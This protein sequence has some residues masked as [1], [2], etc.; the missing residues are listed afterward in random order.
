MNEVTA[1]GHAVERA[2]KVAH[3]LC[4]DA[5]PTSMMLQKRIVDSWIRYPFDAAVT[6]SMYVTSSAYNSGW[7]QSA[8]T[9]M[10]ERRGG[11]SELKR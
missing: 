9:R 6:S 5:H 10:R 2:T 4:Q 11:T 8:A 3:D 1:S 7:P